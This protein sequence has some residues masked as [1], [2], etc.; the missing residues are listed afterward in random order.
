MRGA[1]LCQPSVILGALCAVLVAAAFLAPRFVPDANPSELVTRQTAR[2][3]IL[4][5]GVAAAAL[6]ARGRDV[7][8]WAWTFGCIAFLVHVATAFDQVHN[9]SHAAAIQHV[10]TVSGLG[11]GLF[12]SYA[13]TVLWLVDALWWWIDR[14][15]Y[16][17]RAR[18]LDWVIQSFMA[19]I[20]FNGTVIYETGFIRWAGIVLFVLLAV[21]FVFRQT[22]SGGFV[23][24]PS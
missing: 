8:R 1:S 5:W 4:F 18:W 16:D 2:V 24:R 23:G 6:L 3:A 14:I 19:F 15:G 13:F 9:W 10:E 17:G 11:V 22:A 12:V 20:V 21:L 7:A